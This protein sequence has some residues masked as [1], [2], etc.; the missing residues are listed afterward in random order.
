MGDENNSLRKPLLQDGTDEN[1]Q[2]GGDYVVDFSVGLG[3]QNDSLENGD[4]SV[5]SQESLESRLNHAITI[6]GEPPVLGK[7][8]AI[9][10]FRNR[11]P[12]IRGFYEW[13]KTIVMLPVLIL[14]VLMVMVVL[15]V[16][17]IATKT[18]LAGYTQTEDPMPKWRR[19]L[20]CVT[21]LCG[22]AILFCFGF[23]WIR[24]I[25][26][27]AP[28]EV[29]P[30]VVSNHVSFTDPI[31][32]FWE[33]LPVFV[34]STSHDD[35]FMVGPIIRAMEVIVVDRLSPDSRRL[36]ASEIKRKAIN[37]DYPRVLLFPEGTTTNGR[38]LISFKLG[39][40]RPGVAVQPVVV[41]YPFVHFDISWGDI[42]V[43]NLLFRMLTQ[44]T[45]HMEVEYLPVVYPTKKDLDDPVAF[46][47]KVRFIMAGA[48]NVPETEHTYGDLMLA[49]K[50]SEL[51][52]YPATASM[53]EMGRMEKLFHLTTPEV[54][55]YLEKF[56]R[57]DT[58][59]SGFVTMDEFL[60]ALDI[61]RSPFSEKLF[62]MFDKSEQGRINFREFVAVLGFLS[63]HSEFA[64]LIKSAFEA[65][66]SHNDGTLSQQ[67]LEK[68]LRR[69]FPEIPKSQVQQIICSR[70]MR[71][72]SQ[73]EYV[74]YMILLPKQLCRVFCQYQKVVCVEVMPTPF[75]P[76][77]NT[78]YYDDPGIHV[79][80]R[81]PTQNCNHQG[82]QPRE[83]RCSNVPFLPQ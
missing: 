31:Y 33:L 67:E 65:C 21:R 3:R 41:R 7:Q 13:T 53:V 79:G 50:S 6:L 27:P 70:D 26:R 76:L 55:D 40:F 74:E 45:N 11:T 2:G 54:K 32:H 77:L 46:A 28:R 25:G 47:Q 16:G 64:N 61:P 48:L 10:P 44:V 57:M 35:I 19:R 80:L 38:A 36:A 49:V 63:S 42:S 69:V 24:R 37:N 18:A 81:N 22:R 51:K 4:V 71:C 75:M 82:V 72:L 39:A 14:R 20:F 30:I 62:L 60:E 52:L 83:T 34:S 17:L 58:N 1:L 43:S 66:D 9:D 15:F 5:E 73:I 23:H 12:R 56:H 68:S 8:A 59:R 29:A 78:A